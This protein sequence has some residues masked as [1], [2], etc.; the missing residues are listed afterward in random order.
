M[1]SCRRWP[2]GSGRRFGEPTPPQRLGWP[3]D[4]LGPAYTL[5]F[6]PTGSGKTLAAFLACLD[7]LWRVLEGDPRR[8]HPLYLAPEGA[9]QRRLSETSRCRWRA[10]WRRRTGGGSPHC[11]SDA[12]RP[13]RGHSAEGPSAPAPQAARHPDHDARIAASHAHQPSTRDAPTPSRTSSSTRS[14]PSAP[15]SVAC[16]WPSCWSVWSRSTRPGFVRGSA[17]R[18]PRG[19][20]KR[21]LD[22]SAGRSRVARPGSSSIRAAGRGHDRGRR[23][24]ARS[25]TSSVIAPVRSLDAPRP[26]GSIWPVIERRS[27]ST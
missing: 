22:T 26:K 13:D 15:T 6:A 11:P 18:P 4:G 7:H 24:S 17:S 5:L 9:Q 1:C 3:A 25:W 27:C 21:W 23:P 12:G 10:S 19:R 8:P 14:T 2:P 20:S 16:S